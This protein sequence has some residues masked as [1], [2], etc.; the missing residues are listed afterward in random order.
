MKPILCFLA[1]NFFAA[2]TGCA[3][4]PVQ[5]STAAENSSVRPEQTSTIKS[6]AVESTAED[7]FN[8]EE[9]FAKDAALADR[10]NAAQDNQEKAEYGQATSKPAAK[11]AANKA[12]ALPPE[13]E[14]APAAEATN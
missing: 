4:T 7:S 11:S 14:A 13:E 10:L 5:N 3:D 8:C 12:T 6:T 2:T 1:F 9:D